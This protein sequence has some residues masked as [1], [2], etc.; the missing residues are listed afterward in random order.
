MPERKACQEADSPIWPASSAD[1]S[2]LVLTLHFASQEGQEG[3]RQNKVV[4][5]ILGV[6]QNEEGEH[7][8]KMLRTATGV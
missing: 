6:S 7:A 3:D 8:V 4:A 5:C 1:D 2:K